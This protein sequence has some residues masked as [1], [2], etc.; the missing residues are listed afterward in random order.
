MSGKCP[1][2]NGTFVLPFQGS[3]GMLEE[4]AERIQGPEEV[5]LEVW[6]SAHHKAVVF[7][8]SQQQ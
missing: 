5:G 1:A 6:R 8:N 7:M 2:V 4:K 3:E